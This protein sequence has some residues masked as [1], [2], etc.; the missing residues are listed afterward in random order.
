MEPTA[1]NNP[2]LKI[3]ELMSR[4]QCCRKTVLD[5]I[6]DGRLSAFK[7]GRAHWRISLDEVTRY[8]SESSKEAS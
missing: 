5:A 6:K 4:W 3:S 2:A 7:V 8:E 1:N